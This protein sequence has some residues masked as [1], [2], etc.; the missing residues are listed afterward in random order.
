MPFN[1]GSVT[2]GVVQSFPRYVAAM[3]LM[4]QQGL[5][6]IVLR[7]S[8]LPHYCKVKSENLTTKRSRDLLT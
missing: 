8:E 7:S 1:T 2:A 6:L 5:R 4:P 3:R